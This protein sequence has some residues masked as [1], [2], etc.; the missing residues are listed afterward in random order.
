[1]E[2][3]KISTSKQSKGKDFNC[4]YLNLKTKSWVDAKTFVLKTEHEEIFQITNKK[5]ETQE[6]VEL[7]ITYNFNATYSRVLPFELTGKIKVKDGMCGGTVTIPLELPKLRSPR[8]STCF[9]VFKTLEK[10]V[11]RTHKDGSK[12]WEEPSKQDSY[13]I[14]SFKFKEEDIEIFSSIRQ[15]ISR[16][17]FRLRYH[18][19]GLRFQIEQRIHYLTYKSMKQVLRLIANLMGIPMNLKG[20][21]TIKNLFELIEDGSQNRIF[22]KIVGS[23]EFMKEIK[24]VVYKT[25][26]SLGLFPSF[27]EINTMEEGSFILWIKKALSNAVSAPWGSSHHASF[28]VGN[29]RYSFIH[30]P[31]NPSQQNKVSVS[32]DIRRDFR[33]SQSKF[34]YFRLQFFDFFPM[35][36]W[37]NDMAGF[38]R[39]ILSCVQ[40]L[41]LDD[42]IGFP[43]A[44]K[45]MNYKLSSLMTEDQFPVRI[46]R[47]FETRYSGLLWKEKPMNQSTSHMSKDTLRSFA[48]NKS[49]TPSVDWV[50]L[51]L[52]NLIA[53]A[54]MRGYSQFSNNCQTVVSEIVNLFCSNFH[55]L[56]EPLIFQSLQ[57]QVSGNSSVIEAMQQNFEAFSSHFNNNL[58]MKILPFSLI[59][60]L[61]YFGNYSDEDTCKLLDSKK[62]EKIRSHFDAYYKKPEVSKFLSAVDYSYSNGLNSLREDILKIFDEELGAKWSNSILEIQKNT[63][64]YDLNKEGATSKSFLELPKA[65]NPLKLLSILNVSEGTGYKPKEG[66]NFGQFSFISHLVCILYNELFT[67]RKKIKINDDQIWDMNEALE[68]LKKSNLKHKIKNTQKLLESREKISKENE[69]L[70]QKKYLLSQYYREACYYYYNSV[71]LGVIEKFNDNASC[72]GYL[73][74]KNPGWEAETNEEEEEKN[75]VNT[76]KI[77]EIDTKKPFS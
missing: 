24:S 67:I 63:K 42:G 6:R 22:K 29:H 36:S 41:Q 15:K 10:L 27:V 2:E 75:F 77:L 58:P 55:Q 3:S 14:F 47:E 30:I 76:D 28:S 64:L 7:P 66:L 13:H 70:Y 50:F 38:I 12:V 53:D 20:N 37:I 56:L 54:E 39:S 74:I 44:L 65:E 48:M 17:N 8:Q 40:V 26:C 34:D 45:V 72:L 52:T 51:K 73:L 69:E 49:Q 46:A 9:I 43:N 21:E 18:Q 35:N 19:Y 71:R 62:F 23:S 16:A 61:S 4:S 68:A 25:V 11:I 33:S 32:L 31:N 5:S 59:H 60:Q 57:M 1:M